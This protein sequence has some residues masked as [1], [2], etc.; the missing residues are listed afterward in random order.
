MPLIGHCRPAG[1][2]AQGS[3]EKG[4]TRLWKAGD[5]Q[6]AVFEFLWLP[7]AH[8]PA[9][10]QR[11][12]VVLQ[13]LELNFFPYTPESGQLYARMKQRR[14]FNRFGGYPRRDGDLGFQIPVGPARK[15]S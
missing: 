9:A 1:H 11:Q 14:E 4:K 6:A 5:H 7:V 10:E 15:T 8:Q 13:D 2:R 12:R 3:R